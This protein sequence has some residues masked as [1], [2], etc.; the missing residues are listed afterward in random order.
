[1]SF[2][3]RTEQ[4]GSGLGRVARI[5]VVDSAAARLFQIVRRSA[6][7]RH[8]GPGSLS[9]HRLTPYIWFIDRC[10]GR[11]AMPRAI[12]NAAVEGEKVV[13]HDGVFA[14]D[15]KDET[16]RRAIGEKGWLGIT[17][18]HALRLLALPRMRTAL[19]P[20]GSRW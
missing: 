10:C 8:E 9:C 12:R 1:L 17:Q 14:Q 6:L 18:D 3:A 4:P 19:R 11:V 5:E 16:W 2:V 13:L 20:S 15:E 7:P